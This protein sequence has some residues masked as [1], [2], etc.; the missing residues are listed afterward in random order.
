M[1]QSVSLP[2]NNLTEEEKFDILKNDV[3]INQVAQYI[4]AGKAKKIVLMTGAGISVSAGIPDFRTKG[5]GLYDNLMKYG[6]PE[7]EAMFHID[8]FRQDPTAFYDLSR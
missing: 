5:T 1:G 7:P 2:P 3:S 6:L 4:K 8:Y